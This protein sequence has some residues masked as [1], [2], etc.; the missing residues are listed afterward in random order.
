VDGIR[1]T[2]PRGRT[3]NGQSPICTPIYFKNVG[4]LQL[5]T[6]TCHFAHILMNFRLIFCLLAAPG[7]ALYSNRPTTYALCRD[8][9]KSLFHIR[10]PVHHSTSRPITNKQFSADNHYYENETST[11]SFRNGVGLLF[12]PIHWGRVNC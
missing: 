4:A 5:Y 7:P 10:P 11:I 8:L 6:M 12:P 9:L 1:L 3:G 2:V